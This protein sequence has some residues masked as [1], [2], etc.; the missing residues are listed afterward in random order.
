MNLR[1]TFIRPYR[2]ARYGFH[3]ITGTGAFDSN[4]AVYIHGPIS[5]DGN[6]LKT[7][8]FKHHV[9]QFHGSSCSVASVVSAVNAIRDQQF[10]NPMPISQMD[11]L[12]K[13]R[14]AN[15]K[16][17]MIDQE[18]KGPRGLPLLVLGEVVKS[19]LEAY[20]IR[21]ETLETVPALKNSDQSKSIKDLLW[22]RLQEFEKKGDCLVI[23][24]FD[25][26]AYVP[27]LNIPHIS[28]VGSFD[29]NTGEVIILDVDPEQ[30]KHYKI[31]FERFYKGLSSTYNHILRPFGY[32]SGGYVYIKLA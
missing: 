17:R 20:G 9:K 28:P 29:E 23:I 25:Q 8:L 5:T 19:S 30:E 14:T 13:V 27:T 7:S 18:Y 2:Y 12:E 26:G 6:P 32:G 16:E 22:N 1:R 11:I 31:T 15:W 24:H 10:E 4:R 21:Y 3:K